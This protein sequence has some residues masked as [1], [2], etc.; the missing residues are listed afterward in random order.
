MSATDFI[1]F[2]L[3]GKLASFCQSGSPP[4]GTRIQA[5]NSLGCLG[6]LGFIPKMDLTE[7]GQLPEPEPKSRA[8]VLGT[9][10]LPLVS[11]SHA[12]SPQSHQNLHRPTRRGLRPLHPP[13]RPPPGLSRPPRRRQKHHRQNPHR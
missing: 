2:A 7:N 10:H 1:L 6:S 5:A 8:T 13:P 4:P 9:S 3:E 12:R 11:T